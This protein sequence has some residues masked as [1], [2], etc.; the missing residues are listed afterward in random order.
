MSWIVN[1]LFSNARI[2]TSTDMTASQTD[3]DNAINA[4]QAV[5]YDAYIYAGDP[6]VELEIDAKTIGTDV[7]LSTYQPTERYKLH[8][9]PMTYNATEYHQLMTYLRRPY[10]YVRCNSGNYPNWRHSYDVWYACELV[11]VEVDHKHETGR[12]HVTLTIA[13]TLR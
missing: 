2:P 1:L 12:K 8:L 13:L 6:V 11:G 3:I 7:V 9:L 5:V 4:S 10:M